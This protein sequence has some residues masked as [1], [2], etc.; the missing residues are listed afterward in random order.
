MEY[1][2]Y[3]GGAS[4]KFHIFF[5]AED[6][7]GQYHAFNAYGRIGYNP[8]IQ[9]I[10]GPYST[11]DSAEYAF[12]K[13][14]GQKTKKGYRPFGAEEG[15]VGI[16]ANDFMDNV[17]HSWT[18]EFIQYYTPDELSWVLE[19]KQNKYPPNEDLDFFMRL[20]YEDYLMK[21]KDAS[22]DI[23]Y[24]EDVGGGISPFEARA[25]GYGDIY[26]YT[27]IPYSWDTDSDYDEYIYE[28]DINERVEEEVD[29]EVRSGNYSG[30]SV[31]G[32]TVEYEDPEDKD[33]YIEK[34]I[35]VDYSW[36]AE[37]SEDI[38]QVELHNPIET[39]IK[40]SIGSMIA[41]V[42]ISA[43]G[44]AMLGLLNRTMGDE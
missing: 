23:I 19:Q 40:L 11:S 16:S 12:K 43:L 31:Y 34:E 17:L 30:S 2:I 36:G 18:E 28:G 14:M 38:P 27:R 3:Q 32:T 25:E 37:G 4:N 22:E 5:V 8:R 7:G 20:M 13:K 29:Q 42:G 44:G 39:G 41:V 24:E 10:G 1:L 9:Y 26:A 15:E 33:A 21:F 35:D 6:D